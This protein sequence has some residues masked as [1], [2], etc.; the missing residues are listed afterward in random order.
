MRI[1]ACALALTAWPA[2][3]EARA[4]CRTSTCDDCPRDDAGCSVGGKPVAWHGRCVGLGLHADASEQVD[5]ETAQRLVE[6]A[7]AIW[8]AVRCE[9][10]GKPPSIELVGTDGP[11]AC[12]RAEYVSGAGNAN[13][14]IFRDDSWPF[15][16]AG[17]ELAT[18]SVR[19]RS[20]GEIVDADIE[21]NATLPLL[22]DGQQSSG[23]IVGAH[24]LLSILVHEMGHVLGIDHSIDPDS[25]MQVDLP[26]RVV[27]TTL[28]ADDV[29][30]ICAAYPPAR[31]APACDPTPRGE[32]AAQCALDP[33]TGGACNAAHVGRS[34]SSHAWPLTLL[35]AL[36]LRRW[37]RQPLRR[38]QS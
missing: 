9:P 8:S 25:I 10:S 21:V 16:G 17:R 37:R 36:A 6:E 13:V 5:F 24:D 11:I 15:G 1:L 23:T 14:V 28:G 33:S 38:A 3:S 35:F 31:K 27:R 32:F 20:D 30:A 29:A 18:T 2:P 19:S 12:G 34:A 7:F 22:F 4:F 26:P